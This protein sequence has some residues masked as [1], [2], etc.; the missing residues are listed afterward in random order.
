MTPT[1]AAS[2][3]LLN[4]RPIDGICPEPRPL[5]PR[6]QEV[7]DLFQSLGLT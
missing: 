1:E 3:A 7:G 6:G 4:L 5:L 2:S